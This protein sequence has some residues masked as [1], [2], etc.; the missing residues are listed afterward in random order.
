MR[1]AHQTKPQ[2]LAIFAL[3]SAMLLASMAVSITTVALPVLSR[4]LEAPVAAVQWVV[5]VYLLSVTVTIVVAGRSADLFGHR[6]VLLTGLAVFT[7]SSLLCAAAPDLTLLIAA[8]AVQGIGGAI[9]MALPVSIIRG[10]VS[11]ER[12]GSA[13][14]LLGSMSAIGTALGPSLGGILIA[15]FG[16]RSAFILLAAT[17]FAVFILTI[18]ALPAA[19]NPAPAQRRKA[20]QQPDIAGALLLAIMLFFYAITTTGSKTGLDWSPVYTLP[21]ALLALILFIIVEK[22]APSPLVPVAML[23][24]LP[25][26]ASLLTNLLISTVM[27]AMLVV[28]PFFLSFALQLGDAQTGLVVAV[29]PVVAALAGLPSGYITDRLGTRTVLIVGLMA[30]ALAL[31]CMAFL[32]VAIGTAGYILSLILLT[33]CFQLF[34]AG[35]NTV[36]ML[37]APEERRGILSGLLGLS[38]NLGFMTGASIMATI[39]VA[40][41]GDTELVQAPANL[42]AHAFSVTM[43]IAAGLALLSLLITLSS[44]KK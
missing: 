42:V 25:V 19:S 20:T 9:L 5:L 21:A 44:L 1:F 32:P 27:M 13:M 8:R 10:I 36:I 15:A 38:R 17:G 2:R 33:P 39:F 18:K 31:I 29:G 28:G 40:A 14:G 37:N 26:S 6:L 3:A 16:W 22:R 12:M 41:L 23:R 43:L 7:I 35:N 11:G 24:N 4:V 30:M 34:L